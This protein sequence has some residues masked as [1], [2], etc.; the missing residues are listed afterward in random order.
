MEHHAPPSE[1]IPHKK[2]RNPWVLVGESCSCRFLLCSLSL[3]RLCA[4]SLCSAAPGAVPAS[5]RQGCPSL[6]RQQAC[7]VA[8]NT[9]PLDTLPT[10]SVTHSCPLLLARAQAPLS[11]AACCWAAWWPSRTATAC[12]RSTSCGRVWSRRASRCVC[13]AIMLAGFPSARMFFLPACCPAL[14]LQHGLPDAGAAFLP[15]CLKRVALMDRV[16]RACTAP[17]VH[18][19]VQPCCHSSVPALA[20]A[21]AAGQLHYPPNGL[22]NFFSATNCSPPQVAIMIA[23][24]GYLAVD[25]AQQRAALAAT[26]REQP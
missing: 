25:A 13:H 12:W 1:I 22:W 18:A 19:P 2:K 17:L 11:P 21:P 3:T 7:K 6:A 26:A 4:P 16:Y 15:P 24:G 5:F 9:G 8:H 14:R 23:S 20:A 10:P